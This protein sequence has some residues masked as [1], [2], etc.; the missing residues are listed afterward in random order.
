LL[1][2]VVEVVALAEG[3]DNCQ[4]LPPLGGGGGTDHDHQMVH[5][6]D[7]VTGHESMVTNRTIKIRNQAECLGD[8]E[9]VEG[10]DQATVAFLACEIGSRLGPAVV[11]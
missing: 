1:P 6:C 7:A 2:Y 10:R 11:L 8:G 5:G 9:E 3:A 4:R